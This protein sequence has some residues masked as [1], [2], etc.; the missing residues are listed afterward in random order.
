[1]FTHNPPGLV[2]LFLRVLQAR[3]AILGVFSILTAA[4][5]YGALRIPTD[6]SIDRLVIA[7]DPVS[8]ATAEFERVFPE[9]EQ[10]LLMLEAPDPFT[11]DS[12]NGTAQLE[13][14]LDRIP[15][16]SAQ[17]LL[18]LRPPVGSP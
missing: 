3:R 12:L 17:S 10:A 15:N 4:G 13:H 18:T 2:R 1:M 7:G 6:P 11:P 8:Q 9:S 5:I 14:A 16:V